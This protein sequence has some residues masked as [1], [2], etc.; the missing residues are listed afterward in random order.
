MGSEIYRTYL[1]MFYLLD[2]CFWK[3]REDDLGAMLGGMTPEHDF[4]QTGGIPLDSAYLSGWSEI[5]RKNPDADMIALTDA[6][7]AYYQSNFGFDVS[8]TRGMLRRD[9]SIQVMLADAIRQA[10]EPFRKYAGS[11]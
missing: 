8:Q 3:C 5:S 6:F 1:I 9:D 4:F 2:A 10:D 11:L 7:L